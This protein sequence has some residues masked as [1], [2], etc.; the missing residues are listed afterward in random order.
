[1]LKTLRFQ[2]KLKAKLDCATFV[3]DIDGVLTDGT[4]IYDDTGKVMKRFGPHD[5]EA[6]KLIGAFFPLHFITADARG[7][8]ITQKRVSDM[9]FEAI[10]LSPRERQVFVEELM[11]QNKAVV[12]IGDSLSDIPAMQSAYLSACPSDAMK[13]VK[14]EAN[15]SLSTAGGRGVVAEV[16]SI[17]KYCTR[18]VNRFAKF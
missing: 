2:M 17:V 9:G 10:L 7:F 4:F 6:A 16:Y 13:D 12:F 5:S 11:L 14:K 3:F 1:M 8:N 15:L 18:G